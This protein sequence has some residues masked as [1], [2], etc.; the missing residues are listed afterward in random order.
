MNIHRPA[1][2]N[3]LPAESHSHDEVG[4]RRAL[5]EEEK[6]EWMRGRG[7]AMRDAFTDPAFLKD[8]EDLKVRCRA[9][10]RQPV[11]KLTDAQ[12]DFEVDEL[13]IPGR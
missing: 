4:F 8:L 12:H 3:T 7:Q 13:I 6:R 2:T 1:N 11:R 9:A 10:A 5:S